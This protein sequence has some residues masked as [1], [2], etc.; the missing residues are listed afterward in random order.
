MKGKPTDDEDVKSE[1]IGNAFASHTREWID[2]DHDVM[3]RLLRQVSYRSGAAAVIEE[4]K[5]YMNERGLSFSEVMTW[6]DLAALAQ[7]CELNPH[8]D[9]SDDPRAVAGP[10]YYLPRVYFGL[11]AV[12][13]TMKR[14]LRAS[15]EPDTKGI[16]SDFDQIRAHAFELGAL[17]REYQLSRDNAVDAIERKRTSARLLERRNDGNDRRKDAADLWR[18]PARD[19]ARRR[20]EKNPTPSAAQMA[21]DLRRWLI[22]NVAVVDEASMPKPDTIR[23][24]IGDLRPKRK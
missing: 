6:G 13:L 17:C 4:A 8:P 5:A 2:S 1:V 22:A 19:E 12:G 10:E 11:H 16:W 7:F 20:W 18:K 21:R 23:R 14:F 3:N 15:M 9:P 24:S